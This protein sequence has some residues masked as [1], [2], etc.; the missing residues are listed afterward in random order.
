MRGVLAALILTMLAGTGCGRSEKPG[1]PP[2]TEVTSPAGAAA[3]DAHPPI[4]ALDTPREGS[5]V[6]NKSWGTGWALDDSGIFQVTATADNGAVAVAKTGQP[7][8]GVKE[9]YPNL[10][11]NDKAG[12]IF[13]VP[14]LPP[15]PHSIKV[16]VLAKDSGKILITR[17][18]TV[19]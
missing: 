16:E 5:T 9:A 8:P 11:D 14:D 18:F 15:G 7:F 3:P 12:F 4:A 13:E 2:V 1:P 6:P 19:Q 17:S 10:P